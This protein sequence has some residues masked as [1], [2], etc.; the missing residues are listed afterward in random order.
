MKRKIN[1]NELK[2]PEKARTKNQRKKRTN[3]E[4]LR[5][6]LYKAKS[7]KNQNAMHPHTLKHIAQGRFIS[8]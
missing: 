5:I 2:N 3:T 4:P 1:I 7:L 6:H 8:C